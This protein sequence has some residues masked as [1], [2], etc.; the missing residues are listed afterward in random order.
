MVSQQ[1]SSAETRPMVYTVS[2]RRGAKRPSRAGNHDFGRFSP[3]ISA[4]TAVTK[5]RHINQGV[6]RPLPAPASGPPTRAR[7]RR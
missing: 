7:V 6:S 3:P 5:G 2:I 4:R 1:F